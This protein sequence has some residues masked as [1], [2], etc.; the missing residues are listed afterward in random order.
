M[1]RLCRSDTAPVT[2]VTLHLRRHVSCCHLS[3]G[4]PPPAIGVATAASLSSG[5]VVIIAAA[6][7]ARE[8]TDG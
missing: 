1:A 3:A 4:D 8:Q 2:Q 6:V 7:A 5:N